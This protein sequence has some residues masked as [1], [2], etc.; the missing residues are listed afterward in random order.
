VGGFDGVGEEA[1]FFE[2]CPPYE[3]G[4]DGAGGEAFL[5]KV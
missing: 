5:L 3:D 2:A 1:C 4:F